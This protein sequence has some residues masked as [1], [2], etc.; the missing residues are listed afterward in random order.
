MKKNLLIF[1][2]VVIA[3]L[4][5]ITIVK[6]NKGNKMNLENTYIVKSINGQDVYFDK[7][8]NLIVTNDPKA[9]K[10]GNNNIL[11]KLVLDSR[12]ILDSSPYANHKPLYYNPK[13]DAYGQTDYLKFKE[14][15][16]ISYKQPPKGKIA[17]WAKKEKAYYESL[18]TK[19]ERYIYLVKRSGLKCTMID[20]PDDA[21][22]R[23]D[24]NGRLT[25]PEYAGIYDEVERHR[26]TLKSELFG[27]EW[28]LC[29]G[30]LGDERG[31]NGT[32]VG[33]FNA[34]A[35][36]KIFL[37]AQLGRVSALNLL[38]I[39]NRDGWFGVVKNQMRAME[40]R[41]MLTANG[42]GDKLYFLSKNDYNLF[43]RLEKKELEIMK[44]H[45]I[46]DEFGMIPYLDEII[47]VDWVMDFNQNNTEMDDGTFTRHI[48]KKIE[49]ESTLLD[50]RD[51]N[52]SEYTRK[53]FIEYVKNNIKDFQDRYYF[54]GLPEKWSSRDIEL[55]I[56]SNIL[57][58]KI[59]SLTPIEGYPNAPYYHTPEELI[60]LY[61]AGKLDKKLNPLIPAMYR[62][63]FPKDLKDKIEEYAREHDIKD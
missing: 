26:G 3:I 35:Y 46:Y 44:T 60:E 45:P 4:G 47:G 9:P 25:K 30:V 34:R 2:L 62:E 18:K 42:W 63:Y 37:A 39:F 40:Y 38:Y 53:E 59:I 52:A 17:P 49:D 19:R 55:Y 57:E 54:P 11:S 41:L 12:K 33:G 7:D 36:Q 50:P 16:D 20:I 23:V 31:F 22:G 28:N 1:I 56:D 27:G 51:I 14:W 10:Q 13:P 8:T 21:I 48:R 61:E 15:L 24:E 43:D 5:I 32:G 6:I 58:S 29:A